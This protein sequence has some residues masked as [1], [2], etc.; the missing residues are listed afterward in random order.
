MEVECIRLESESEDL[1]KEKEQVSKELLDINR[2]VLAWEK[3]FQMANETKKSFEAEKGAE[4]EMGAMQNEIHRMTVRYGQLKRAQEKL[5]Q[6]LQFT[7]IRRESFW[8]KAESSEKRTTGKAKNRIVVQHKLQ[9]LRDKIKK[10]Q[11]VSFELLN[12]NNFEFLF[13]YKKK[14]RKNY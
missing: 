1:E 4:G 9:T 3:K 6:D 8:L 5:S 11:C 14:P 12:V 7:L 2:T 13:N 10:L